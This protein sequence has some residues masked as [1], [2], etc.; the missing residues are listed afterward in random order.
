MGETGRSEVATYIASLTAD[1]S[2]MSRRQGLSTLA[3]LLDMARLE[4]EGA[5]RRGRAD[6]SS[7]PEVDVL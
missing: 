2:E 5:A 7:D 4:A 3:Y 6:G 1:L